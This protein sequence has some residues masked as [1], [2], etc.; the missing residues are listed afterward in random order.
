MSFYLSNREARP[1]GQEPLEFIDTP[2]V[3][4]ASAG[5]PMLVEV[6]PTDDQANAAGD[7]PARP[8]EARPVAVDPRGAAVTTGTSWLRRRRIRGGLLP[9]RRRP[10]L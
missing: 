3:P 9:A 4:V 7:H 6:V 5:R 2:A 10:T 1:T 8:L